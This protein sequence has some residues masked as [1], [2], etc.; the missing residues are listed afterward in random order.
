MT[1][2]PMSLAFEKTAA[3]LVFALGLAG[4]S[5]SSEEESFRRFLTWLSSRPPASRPTDLVPPYRR[6]LMKQG[7]SEQDADREAQWMSVPGI[8]ADHI[9]V[10]ERLGRRLVG[11]GDVA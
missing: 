11:V 3:A 8:F 5:P 10:T 6:E 4:Q 2:A 7:L 1:S 9:G